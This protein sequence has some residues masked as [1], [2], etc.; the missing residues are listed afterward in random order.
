MIG[1]N[2][3]AMMELSHYDKKRIHHL[4]YFTWIEQ[5]N[6]DVKELDRQWHEYDDYWSGI[7]NLTSKIDKLILEFNEKV[8]HT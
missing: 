5:Q 2:I 3:D 8:D 6:F 7:Q 4:K 1:Q